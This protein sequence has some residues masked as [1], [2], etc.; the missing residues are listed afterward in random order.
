MLL[1]I[2]SSFLSLYR[3]RTVIC[4]QYMNQSK[5]INEVMSLV[6]KRSKFPLHQR[7]KV[8]RKS[9][10]NLNGLSLGFN[11]N[12]FQNQMSISKRIRSRPFFWITIFFVE[13]LGIIFLKGIPSLKYLLSRN[14]RILYILRSV[15]YGLVRIYQKALVQCKKETYYLEHSGIQIMIF[16]ISNTMNLCKVVIL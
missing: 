4:K 6:D 12:S 3:R 7:K 5:I 1:Q 14:R 11:F 13:F 10:K 2:S 9:R 15:I 8:R 16:L